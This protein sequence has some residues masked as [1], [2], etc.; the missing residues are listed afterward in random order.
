MRF[1]HFFLFSDRKLSEFSLLFV[2]MN[3]TAGSSLVS[4]PKKD[5][6]ALTAMKLAVE[7]ESGSL[8]LRFCSASD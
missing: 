6:A 1:I 2:C 3:F 8:P 7:T 5:Y 4:P